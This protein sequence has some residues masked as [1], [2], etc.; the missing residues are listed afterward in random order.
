MG[1]EV[2]HENVKYGQEH[3]HLD[4]CEGALG[5][6]TSAINNKKFDL[7]IMEGVLEHI[8]TLQDTIHFLKKHLTD[9]GMVFFG[10][11]D[12][13]QFSQHD[14]LYQQFSVEHVNFFCRESLENLL[15]M[16]GF[17]TVAVTTYLSGGLEMLF[18]LDG[19]EKSYDRDCCGAKYMEKYLSHCEDLLTCLKE[20]ISA[21]STPYY[22]WGSGTHT[23][24]LFQSGVFKSENVVGIIDSNRNYQ[25]HT[26]YGHK[27]VDANEIKED[28]PIVI[29][30]QDAQQAILLYIEDKLHLN[31]ECIKKLS[32]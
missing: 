30:T 29:S 11:P 10:V 31:N 26:I 13:E 18:Q 8:L 15:Y 22:I 12:L 4:V 7:I 25:G 3:Y 19:E 5:G 32:Q 9:D 20:K 1:L 21:L 27:I 6:D 23:A 16:N 17:K 24:I 2:A 28:F 14:D